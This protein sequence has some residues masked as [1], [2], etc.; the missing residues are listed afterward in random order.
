MRQVDTE[1]LRQEQ[2]GHA[3]EEGGAVHV[4]GGAERNDEAGDLA[5]HAELL[6]AV[7]SVVGMVALELTSRTR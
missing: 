2:H 5:R 4:H 7:R 6:L 3:L 1:H